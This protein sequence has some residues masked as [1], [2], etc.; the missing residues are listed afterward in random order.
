M[1]EKGHTYRPIEG[2]VLG[3]VDDID[4]NTIHWRHKTTV[5]LIPV[6]R[7]TEYFCKEAT[8]DDSAGEDREGTAGDTLRQD[9]R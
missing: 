2:D 7:F 8:S 3:T 5:F 4:G 1:I 6:E 9:P